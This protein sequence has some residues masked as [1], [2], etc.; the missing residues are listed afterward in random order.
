MS[1]T[2]SLPS[3][4]RYVFDPV[5]VEAELEVTARV[6]KAAA[7]ALMEAQDKLKA[8]EEAQAAMKAQLQAAEELHKVRGKFLFWGGMLSSCTS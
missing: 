5:D 8:A 6:R 2:C 1:H 3:P 4:R 7:E